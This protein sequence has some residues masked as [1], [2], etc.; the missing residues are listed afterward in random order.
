MRFANG[1][2]PYPKL[3]SMMLALSLMGCSGTPELSNPFYK[4]YE[5]AFAIDNFNDRD[6]FLKSL[7]H[8]EICEVVVLSR[9]TPTLYIHAANVAELKGSQGL[10][11]AA[12]CI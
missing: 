9:R 6:V 5:K 3:L 4:Y 2:N 7:S 1:V 11:G 8:I 12:G 10:F